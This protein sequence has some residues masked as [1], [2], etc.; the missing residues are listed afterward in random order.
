MKKI[1]CLLKM[2]LQYLR[3]LVHRFTSYSDFK[4]AKSPN[5]LYVFKS[6]LGTKKIVLNN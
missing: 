5:G 4:R 1:I 6:G 2:F 3:L